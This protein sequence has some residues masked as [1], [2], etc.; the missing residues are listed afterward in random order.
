VNCF[1]LLVV[2]LLFIA[3]PCEERS[4]TDGCNAD[5]CAGKICIEFA[6][7]TMRVVFG[8]VVVVS[9]SGIEFATLVEELQLL[10]GVATT[11]LAYVLQF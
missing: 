11:A 4:L 6:T 1:S 9:C 3:F 7:T 10:Q 5:Y 8:I 2:H